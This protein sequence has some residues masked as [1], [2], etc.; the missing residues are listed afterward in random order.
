VVI[1]SLIGTLADY[2]M[3]SLDSKLSDAS[4]GYVD[5][6]LAGYSITK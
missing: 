2:T 6:A 4:V 1:N 3:I 5:Y